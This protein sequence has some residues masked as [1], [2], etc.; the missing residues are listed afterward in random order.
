MTELWGVSF[1][2]KGLS[3]ANR[4]IRRCHIP[5]RS[6]RPSVYGAGG[7]H[8]RLHFC[9]GAVPLSCLSRDPRLGCLVCLYSVSSATTWCFISPAV[10]T[11]PPLTNQV[12]DRA[13]CTAPGSPPRDSVDS[14]SRTLSRARK[15]PKMGWVSLEV[16]PRAPE[17]TCGR[18]SPAQRP[19]PQSDTAQ[20][21]PTLCV[22]M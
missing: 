11:T 20:R 13:T 21:P 1:A 14:H 6:P 17:D 7:N 22:D 10:T 3:E 16:Q 5:S 9:T 2:V 12:A 19:R 15:G 18:Y 8:G 4:M